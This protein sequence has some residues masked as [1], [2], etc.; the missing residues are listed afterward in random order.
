MLDICSQLCLEKCWGGVRSAEVALLLW[1]WIGLILICIGIYVLL[2]C[3]KAWK[4]I[5]ICGSL[6]LFSTF[7][8]PMSGVYRVLCPEDLSGDGYMWLS[9]NVKVQYSSNII[10]L[11]W[12][13]P[14]FVPTA[15]GMIG[16]LINKDKVERWGIFCV[17]II[18]YSTFCFVGMVALALSFFF[19]GLY[20]YPNKKE[21]ICR[22]LHWKN[23]CA[24][25]VGAL[26]CVYILGNVLQPKP[27]DVS[28]QFGRT[29]YTEYWEL[30]IV[31][32]LSW[33]VWCFILLKKERKNYLMYCAG[34]ILFLLP[35]FS[36]GM[37]NDLVMRSSIPALFVIYVLVAKNIVDPENDKFYRNLLIGCLVLN[38]VGSVNELVQAAKA[39]N[40]YEAN[41]F[42]YASNEEYMT[43][44][45]GWQ[46]VNWSEEDSIIRW[47]IK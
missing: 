2:G 4:L 18:L 38:S 40:G 47:I 30:L 28:M 23:L 39:S 44:A 36:Y 34:L 43:G 27:E 1:I 7:I 20:K 35:F 41:K 16:L 26:L 5:L 11:R 6:F 9:F 24:L 17:P 3:K 19:V 42:K 31:F 12:V 22:A 45:F 13:F 21:Y 25:A 15:A 14:Q 37:Y 46:Y 29:D 10:L 33:M 8:V 32:Q